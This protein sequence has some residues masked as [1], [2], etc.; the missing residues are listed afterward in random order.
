MILESP[1]VKLSR[2]EGPLDLLLYLI[3]RQEVDIHDIP[4]SEITRQYLSALDDLQDMNLEAAGEFIMMVSYLLYIKAQMLLPQ[5][6]IEGEE[7]PRRPLVERLLEYQKFKQIG[8]EFKRIEIERSSV[9]PRGFDPSLLGLSED[10]KIDF[11][12]YELYKTY[13]D[14]AK[15]SPG[16]TTALVVG[17]PIDIAERMNY[18]LDKFNGSSKVSF[19]ELSQGLNRI[20]LVATFMALLELVKTG[21][22]S[23]RQVKLFGNI[24]VYANDS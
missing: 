8:E 9:Y 4:V 15:L 16:F 7:D 3:R 11:D 22:L 6:E 21:K 20:Y 18:I 17:S 24:F 10:L 2:F 1:E 12:V 19:L 23:V 13:L 5:P 14:L